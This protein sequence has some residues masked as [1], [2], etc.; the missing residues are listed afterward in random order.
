[1]AVKIA[2]KHGLSLSGHNGK[3]FTSQLARNYDLILVME[4]TILN[5]LGG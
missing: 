2:E 4:K 3:Q 1:M 5:K